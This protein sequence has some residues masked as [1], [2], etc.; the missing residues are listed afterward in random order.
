ML[1]VAGCFILLPGMVGTV[2]LVPHVAEM[3]PFDNHVFIRLCPARAGSPCM[4]LTWQALLASAA[5][6]LIMGGVL[7][8]VGVKRWKGASRG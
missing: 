7:L 1:M 2:L 5:T 4:P 6:S 3:M 8:L